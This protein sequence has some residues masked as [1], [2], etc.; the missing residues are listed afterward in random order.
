MILDD[1]VAQ[2]RVE[3]EEL[4]QTT[5]LRA[6]V[7]RVESTERHVRDYA[8]ALR[9]EDIRL[10]AEIKKASPTKGVLNSEI[11]PVALAAT[12]EAAGAHAISIL[13]DEKFFRGSLD[14]LARVARG[15]SLPL[16][17][18]DFLID[19]YQVYEAVLAG[20]AS[21][22]LIV[23]ILDDRQLAE[24]IALQRSLGM[25]PQVEVH[26]ENEVER[27]LKADALIVGIN[28]RD[29]RTFTVDLATTERL[30]PLIPSDRI[31]VSESGIHTSADV[32]RLR[33]ADVQAMHI[34]EALMV[35]SD[36]IQKARELFGK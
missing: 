23:A 1:I 7:E 21:A 18:K 15:C 2:K 16:L 33:A 32:A 12:Y 20:A 14:D 8:D 6:L 29:L 25:E 36:P 28:N 35:S 26:D 19:E 30:R 5:P 4:K 27:A 11:D 31:V 13:T 34:G 17:R 22:L 24:L 9:G 3:L 10:I